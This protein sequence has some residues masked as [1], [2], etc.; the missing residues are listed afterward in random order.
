MITLE[1]QNAQA[2]NR[3]KAEYHARFER[4]TFD[5]AK[6]DCPEIVKVYVVGNHGEDFYFGFLFVNDQG[7]Q[8]ELIFELDENTESEG[9]QF[10]LNVLRE[11]GEYR[12]TA[13]ATA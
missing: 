2:T 1:A 5:P 12:L 4:T 7:Y 9:C 6:P 3:N 10:P 8:G 13:K 11:I